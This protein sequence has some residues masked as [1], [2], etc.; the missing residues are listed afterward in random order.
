MRFAVVLDDIDDTDYDMFDLQGQD[1]LHDFRRDLR[2]LPIFAEALD[3]L[4][5]L[6]KGHNPVKEYEKLLISDP[7]D[8]DFVSDLS[9]SKYVRLP[10]AELEDKPV[11]MS[12]SLYTANMKGVLDF[13]KLKDR[14]EAIE[15]IAHALVH[16]GDAEDLEEALPVAMD[17]LGKPR[18]TFEG[19][20]KEAEVL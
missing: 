14:G 19:I 4:F 18:D 7:A 12:L 8:P 1:G 10:D 3:G 16:G 2:W 6:D 9:T 11:K 20:S 15:N 5:V 17:L 13:G